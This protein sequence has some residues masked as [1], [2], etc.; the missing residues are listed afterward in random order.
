V[1][2]WEVVHARNIACGMTGLSRGC[3]FTRAVF[4]VLL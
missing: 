3:N 2:E 4:W 1:V